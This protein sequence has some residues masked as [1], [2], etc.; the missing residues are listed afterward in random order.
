MWLAEDL[1]G[2]AGNAAGG[3]GFVQ[4]CRVGS[5]E[6]EAPILCWWLSRSAAAAAAAARGRQQKA[7]RA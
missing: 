7:V 3:G 4:L 2:Y 1:A 6:D 5:A